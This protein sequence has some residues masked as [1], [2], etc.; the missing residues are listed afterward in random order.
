MKRAAAPLSSCVRAAG[1]VFR[2]AQNFMSLVC[3]ETA[4]TARC[5][6]LLSVRHLVEVAFEPLLYGREISDR[7][8]KQNF[9]SSPVPT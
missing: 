1:R 3:A 9:A 8:P 5:G 7:H 4:L 6:S 2:S